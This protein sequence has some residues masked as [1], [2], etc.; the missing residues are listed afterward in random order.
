MKKDAEKRQPAGGNMAQGN[1]PADRSR[2]NEKAS[3]GGA[4]NSG[5]TSDDPEEKQAIEKQGSLGKKQPLSAN[6]KQ[7]Q[8]PPQQGEGLTKEDIPDSTNESTGRMGSGL[9]QDSN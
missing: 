9:R 2:S 6:E 3:V 4:Y 8:Q 1:Q 7:Q 5:V